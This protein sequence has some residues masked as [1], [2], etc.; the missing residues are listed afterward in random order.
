MALLELNIY[1]VMKSTRSQISHVSAAIP[2][3]VLRLAFIPKSHITN[4]A[5]QDSFVF[6]TKEDTFPH[7]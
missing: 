1:E 2:D 7:L 5:N 3:T 4:Q 6:S